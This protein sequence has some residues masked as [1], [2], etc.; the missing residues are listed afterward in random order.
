MRYVKTLHFG[1]WMFNKNKVLILVDHD[2]ELYQS[3]ISI[4]QKEWPKEINTIQSF[5]AD[6]DWLQAEKRAHKL[7][8]S[9]NNFYSEICIQAAQDLERSCREQES[10]NA[11]NLLSRLKPLCEKLENELL[12]SV[13]EI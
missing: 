11:E 10:L 3:I 1:V 5:I 2:L 13:D 12:L 7:K 9:L 8:G 6:K 4:F